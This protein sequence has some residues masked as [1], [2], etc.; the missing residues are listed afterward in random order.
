MKLHGNFYSDDTQ[1]LDSPDAA[2]RNKKGMSLEYGSQSIEGKERILCRTKVPTAS[3]FQTAQS[4]LN[5]GH[6]DHVVDDHIQSPGP[7]QPKFD[8]KVLRDLLK[9]RQGA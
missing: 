3:D 1:C 7:P 2:G 9:W 8:V 4:P 5:Y 6:I